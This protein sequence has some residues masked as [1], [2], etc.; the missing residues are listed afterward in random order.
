TKFTPFTTRPAVTSR[1]GITRAG[2]TARTVPPPAVPPPMRPVRWD[3]ARPGTRHTG[4]VDLAQRVLLI[5]HGET[6]WSTARRHTRP[7]ALPLTAAGRRQADEL[8]GRLP[9][10]DFGLV[11]T[12]PLT[13]SA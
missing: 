6:G 10:A 2:C 7:P 12:S 1:Q 5:R 8:R 11:L 9:L 4:A 3:A 13:R